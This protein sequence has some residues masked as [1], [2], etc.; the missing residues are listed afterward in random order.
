MARTEAQ[1]KAQ[2][3]YYK[4]AKG[5]KAQKK[6]Q[7]KYYKSAKGKKSQLK[8]HAK[9]FVLKLADSKDLEQLKGLIN[10]REK[11]LDENDDN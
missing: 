10:Q 2:E 1:K 4:S 8:S 7:E 3:K 11:E 9:T 5:K 6:A